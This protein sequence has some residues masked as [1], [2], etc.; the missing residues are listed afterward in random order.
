M[1][2]DRQQGGRFGLSAMR[3]GQRATTG[4][5][6]GLRLAARTGAGDPRAS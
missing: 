1:T 4:E 2:T 3:G 5:L 6:Y